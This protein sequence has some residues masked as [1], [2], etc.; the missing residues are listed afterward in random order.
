MDV[1]EWEFHRGKLTRKN[2]VIPLYDNRDRDPVKYGEFSKEGTFV[3]RAIPDK[4]ANRLWVRVPYR[5]DGRDYWMP[6]IDIMKNGKIGKFADQIV[7]EVQGC[8]GKNI[9]ENEWFTSSSPIC[10]AARLGKLYGGDELVEVTIGPTRKKYKG[11]KHGGIKSSSLTDTSLVKRSYRV[12]P[13][14]TEML[15]KGGGWLARRFYRVWKHTVDHIRHQGPVRVFTKLA[16]KIGFFIG[17]T[18]MCGT[19]V[20]LTASGFGTP[21]AGL[22]VVSLIFFRPLINMA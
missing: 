22:L 11:C 6:T 17:W 8:G 1:F 10:V 20:S 3:S 18:L 15:R 13:H 16:L 7:H 19:I 5:N 4:H 12:A 14:G 2:K 9:F 21:V